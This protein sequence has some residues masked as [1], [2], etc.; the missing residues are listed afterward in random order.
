MIMTH[1]SCWFSINWMQSQKPE[2]NDIFQKYFVIHNDIH[3]NF[4]T[5]KSVYF[6]LMILQSQWRCQQQ[7]APVHQSLCKM[8]TKAIVFLAVVNAVLGVS[9]HQRFSTPFLR[10]ITKLNIN[11]LINWA[12]PI[13]FHIGKDRMFVRFEGAR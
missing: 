13:Q 6:P 3:M 4:K 9:S 12:V 7:L 11:H 1:C 8:W 5:R 2:Y 10:K